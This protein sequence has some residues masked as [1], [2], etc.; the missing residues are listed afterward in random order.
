M[1]NEVTV[2]GK[3]FVVKEMKAIDLDSID[4]S[5]T[6]EAIKKQVMI[7]TNMN[8]SDYANLTVR[9]RLSI[10]KAIN[11]VNGLNDFQNPIKE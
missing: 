8:E 10:I 4:F 2:D 7:S 6:K 3:S 1:E 9:E 5:N 11:E